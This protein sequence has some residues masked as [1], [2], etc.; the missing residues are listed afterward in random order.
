[1]VPFNLFNLKIIEKEEDQQNF[2]KEKNNKIFFDIN[3]NLKQ[4]K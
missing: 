1:M 2:L 4:I 3:Q